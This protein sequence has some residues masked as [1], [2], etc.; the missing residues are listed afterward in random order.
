MINQLIHDLINDTLVIYTYSISNTLI[1]KCSKSLKLK[2]A[3]TKNLE[4]A[5]IIIGLSYHVKN[6]INILQYVKINNTP[7]FMI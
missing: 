4:D 2:V 6:N 1:K 7:I 5:H 3:F